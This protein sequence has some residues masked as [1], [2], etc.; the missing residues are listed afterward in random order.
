VGSPVVVVSKSHT[1][2]LGASGRCL[3]TE[4]AVLFGELKFGHRTQ[5]GQKKRYKD[6]LKKSLKDFS[7]DHRSWENMAQI[8]ATWRTATR[9]AAALFEETRH[10][11]AE[12]KRLER[13]SRSSTSPS[14]GATLSCP[15]CPRLFQA[16]IGLNSHMRARTNCPPIR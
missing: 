7:I 16:R 13:K 8:R 15:L 14:P 12:I 4:A 11:A 1:G 6:S 10:K 3:Q 9:K 2:G 5:G